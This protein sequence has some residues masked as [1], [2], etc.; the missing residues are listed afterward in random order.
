M[1]L[2][3]FCQHAFCCQGA[4]IHLEVCLWPQRISSSTNEFRVFRLGL[5]L[6]NPSVAAGLVNCV[7]MLENDCNVKLECLCGAGNCMEKGSGTSVRTGTA[8]INGSIKQ[9]LACMFAKH[10]SC[11]M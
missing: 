2:K 11:D 4:C 5:L 7:C 6:C 9:L 10:P 8:V 1:L 3:G